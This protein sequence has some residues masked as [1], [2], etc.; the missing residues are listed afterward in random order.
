ML[1]RSW[2]LFHGRTFPPGRRLCLREMVELATADRPDV[3]CLQEVP[4]WALPKLEEWSGMG[5]HWAVA[6]RGLVPRALA[7]AREGA[8]RARAELT[9]E[10]AAQAH[11][12]LYRELA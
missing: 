2:N 6:K 7:A 11:L 3:L 1:I 8:L 9:W 12:E 4:L 10:A 5:A